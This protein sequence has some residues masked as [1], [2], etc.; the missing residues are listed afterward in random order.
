[1]VSHTGARL[2]RASAAPRVRVASPKPAAKRSK[3]SRSLPLP[4]VL[5]FQGSVEPHLRALAEVGAPAVAVRRREQ[6]EGLTHLV[7]PGGEST[8]LQKLLDL[9]GLWEPIAELGAS[10]RLAIFGTCAGAILLGRQA[11]ECP[12]RLGLIDVTVER[13]AYGRQIDSFAAP[14]CF[15]GTPMEGVFIR[16]PKLRDPGPRVEV[17]ATHDECPVLV[18]EGRLLA[19]AFHPELTA[20]RAIHR[21]FLGL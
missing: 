17:L 15:R 18:R 2:P 20:E 3:P 9:Y 13:N 8:T 19:A 11:E 5:A 21:Y 6:L 14:L 10:G 4:G 16:A 7:L 1:M 12:P